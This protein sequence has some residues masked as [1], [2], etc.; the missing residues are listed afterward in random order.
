MK[1]HN[2]LSVVVYDHLQTAPTSNPSE[3]CLLQSP[4]DS[5]DIWFFVPTPACPALDVMKIHH[6][7]FSA[8]TILSCKTV[9]V[10]VQIRT[11]RQHTYWLANRDP[12]PAPVAT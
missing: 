5:L 1:I 8:I 11:F 4:R 7:A 12:R 10:S 2:E 3:S 9:S 6:L